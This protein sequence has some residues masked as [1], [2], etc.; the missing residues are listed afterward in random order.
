MGS[1]PDAPTELPLGPDMPPAATCGN[2]KIEPGEE[3]DPP[4]SCP[5]TCPAMGCT[6]FM[7]QG[8][9]A[10]C[11]A[12]CVQIAPQTAC[13][14]GD[15]CCPTAPTACTSVN[16]SD[17]AIKCDN[18]M[19]EGMETCD[20]LSSCPTSC[21]AQG[22]ELRK[23]VNP[24]SCTAACV[25]DRKQTECVSGDGCC[26]SGCNHNTDAECPAACGNGV[27]ETGETCEGATCTSLQAS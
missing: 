20:P 9:A 27:V 1:A 21:P 5:T 13:A 15:G 25:D 19:R 17:C 22:C 6:R 16:D 2:G 10:A 26:P 23:L 3:C 4:G 8:A 7:L 12:R 11:T 14:S 18:G 24:A